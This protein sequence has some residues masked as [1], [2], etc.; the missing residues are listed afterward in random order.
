MDDA[1]ST[2]SFKRVRKEAETIDETSLNP[3]KRLRD[4]NEQQGPFEGS[5]TSQID[6][7]TTLAK[8]K[9]ASKGKRGDGRSDKWATGRKGKRNRRCQDDQLQ[10]AT[11]SR[12]EFSERAENVLSPPDSGTK[13]ERLPKKKYAI[14]IGFCGAG[15]NGMQM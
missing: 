11:E 7:H 10:A 12:T 5:G 4:D 1:E 9:K 15:Y 14:L 13:K 3:S 2:M 6:G 8:A